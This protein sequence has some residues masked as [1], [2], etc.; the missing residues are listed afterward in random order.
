ME[1]E[2]VYISGPITNRPIL[3]AREAFSQKA[4]HLRSCG[5]DVVN[6]MEIDHSGDTQWSEYLR[7]DL[8]EMLTHCDA[9]APLHGWR[10]SKG[11]RLEMYVAKSLGLKIFG[12]KH[13]RFIDW[14]LHVL[15]V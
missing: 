6:P 7:R 1:K 12:K 4:G 15:R 11:A 8:I 9:I 3:A 14:M 10:R 2:T 13:S 5:F